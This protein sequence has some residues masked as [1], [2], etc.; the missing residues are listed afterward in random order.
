[1]QAQS[2][3]PVYRS[4]TRAS[5][6]TGRTTCSISLFSLFP[7]GITSTLPARCSR[8]ELP[9]RLCELHPRLPSSAVSR[10]CL[11]RIRSGISGSHLCRAVTVR[12]SRGSSSSSKEELGRGRDC[13]SYTSDPATSSSKARAARSLSRTGEQSTACATPTHP[14]RLPTALPCKPYGV[15]AH[16]TTGLTWDCRRTASSRCLH[17]SSSSSSSATVTHTRK[18]ASQRL[19]IRARSLPSA[20]A[21]PTLP[22]PPHAHCRLARSERLKDRQQSYR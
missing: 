10:H 4:W 3:S 20:P 5:A 17:S 15:C 11:Q 18:T 7:L 12:V 19:S 13:R 14:A 6:C 1:M 22:T 8:R 9:F 21:A 2:R 16:G